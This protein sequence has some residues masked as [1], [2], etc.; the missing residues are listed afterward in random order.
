MT[1]LNF[2]QYPRARS[3]VTHTRK[4][5]NR[6]HGRLAD[7]VGPYLAGTPYRAD[8]P[9]LQL[10]VLAT[11]IDSVLATYDLLAP[12]GPLTAAQKAEYYAGGLELGRAFGLP[13]EMMPPT[14]DDFQTYMDSMLNS[15]LL[16]VGD[17]AREICRAL[18]A[19][20]V[21]G[22][23]VRRMS[24]VSLG[25]TPPRLREQYGFHWGEAAERRLQRLAG[26]ARRLRPLAPDA[27]VVHP[28]ALWAEWRLRRA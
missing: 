17:T 21:F 10:W 13:R 20:P 27:L 1:A 12:G 2:Q 23:M 7:D 4:C 22:P 3:A 5:H 25:L 9:L 18:F 14:Y 19:P 28:Q 16:T 11:L 6:V 26:A 15:D 24:F 8:D